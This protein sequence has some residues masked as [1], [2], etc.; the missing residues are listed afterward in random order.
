MENR[1]ALALRR[2]ELDFLPTPSS[3]RENRTPTG[4]PN[5]KTR[6][7]WLERAR[8]SRKPNRPS[9]ALNFCHLCSCWLAVA[10]TA[11]LTL[12]QYA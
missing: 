9:P 1:G 6:L 11:F 3:S 12:V 7:S 10:L 2:F 8:A 4:Y 5:V